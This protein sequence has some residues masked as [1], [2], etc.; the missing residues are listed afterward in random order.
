ME[1][2]GE[3]YD[4]HGPPTPEEYAAAQAVLDEALGRTAPGESGQRGAA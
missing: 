1:W 2:L 4:R 3:L